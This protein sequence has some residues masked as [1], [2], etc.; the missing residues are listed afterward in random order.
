VAI[1]GPV[2]VYFR[3]SAPAREVHLAVVTV[4]NRKVIDI[5]ARGSFATGNQ[6]VQLLLV[7]SQGKTLSNGLYYFYV[8][9]DGTPRML[10]KFVVLR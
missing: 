3:L 9:A 7:D 5:T 8:T 6:S 10:G 2:T 4:A 1:P